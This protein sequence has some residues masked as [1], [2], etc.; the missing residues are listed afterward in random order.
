M[1]HKRLII[2]GNRSYGLAHSLSKIFPSA[3]F[4]SRSSS[5]SNF[6]RA[7]DRRLFAQKSLDYDVYINC[8]CL[9]Q[10]RQTLLLEEVYKKWREKN[11]K[12][13]IL[14]LGS[15]ADTPVKGT[16]WIYPIEKKALRNYCRNLSLAALGD[17][18]SPPSGIR[19][20]Y[21][22]P[23]Y[24]TTPKMEEKTPDVDKIDTDYLA[25]IIGWLIEQPANVNIS[26]FCLDPIQVRHELP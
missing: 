8:S 19:V 22:S 3:E 26:E 1:N 5:N 13:Q 11:K 12:G 4:F 17:Q 7:E 21:V 9:A 25:G 15:T 20:T 10:F 24:L 2:S 14:C 6:A 23:G 18:G 16:S